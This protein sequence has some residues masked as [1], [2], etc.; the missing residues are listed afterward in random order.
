MT[1]RRRTGPAIPMLDVTPVGWAATL[2]IIAGLLALDWYVLGRRPH[3]IGLGE[4]ARWSILYIAIA[5]AFGVAFS[6]L[7]GWDLGGQ[8]FAGYVV[9][10]SLSV[11]NLFVFVLI[12]GSFAVPA[13]Q[14]PKALSIGIALALALRAAFIVVGA[15]LLDLFAVTFLV[16]G[17]VLIATAV[18]LFRHRDQDPDVEDNLIVRLAR[19]AL[20]VSDRYDDGRIITR[21]EGQRMMTP[22]FLAL[23]AIG[24]SDLLFAFDSIPAV[25][26]VTDHAYIVFAA[27]AFAL[28]GL[29]R[30][31]SS[32]PVCLTA[33]STCRRGSR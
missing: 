28:L 32:S 1:G 3:V 7:N 14:Q 15:T 6:L 24:S 5:L 29:A 19:R 33:W 31:S 21:R 22:L 11:D 20:P 30:C 4:A 17:A 27:N 2:A 13:A 12:I 9:E 10:K 25:F 18:Q 26:G 8:Y 23:L 16:F